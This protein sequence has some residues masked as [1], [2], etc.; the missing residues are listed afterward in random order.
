MIEADDLPSRLA[1]AFKEQRDVPNRSGLARRMSPELSYGRHSGPA[2]STARAAAVLVLLFRRQGRWHLPITKRPNA[3]SRHGGQISLPGGRMEPGETAEEAATREMVEELG[4]TFPVNFLGRLPDRYVFASD[5]TVTP[6]VGWTEDEP[7]WAPDAREVDRVVD[8]PLE[9]LFDPAA[10][11]KMLIQRGPLSFHA[12][13][14]EFQADR[15]WG[16][17]AL[18]LAELADAIQISMTTDAGV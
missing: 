14:F 15:I 1:T 2:P 8:L 16:A 7:R 18:I 11:C 12:P 9:T 6:V 3:L 13:C 5:Y 4:V 17:T 10:V